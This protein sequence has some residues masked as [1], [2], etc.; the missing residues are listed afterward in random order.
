MAYDQ[1]GRVDQKQRT[2]QALVDAARELIVQGNTPT[3]E[4]AASTARVSRTTAYR[5]FPSQQALLFA[6]Y[7]ET[8]TVSLLSPEA[9]DDPT[10]RLDTVVEA[11]TRRLV[12]IETAQRAMLRLSLEASAEER[13]KLFLRQGRAIGWI[14]EALAPLQNQFSIAQ[15]HRL[16]LAIR[17]TIGIESYVWL[18]DVAR[19]SSDDAVATMRWS[20]HA[21]L[22]QVLNGS[23]LPESL[24]RRPRK[25]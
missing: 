20:A 19:L 16:A 7:P 17:A 25:I 4:E 24:P 1:T 5:Y 18:T 21:L 22:Q 14:E 11:F 12:E 2:R 13:A 15:I 3:V 6:A 8:D 23:T 9:S 10:E